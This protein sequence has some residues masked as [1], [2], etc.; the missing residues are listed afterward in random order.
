MGIFD[1]SNYIVNTGV[2]EQFFQCTTKIILLAKMI[3]LINSY[4]ADLADIVDATVSRCTRSPTI[5]SCICTAFVQT[6]LLQR[7]SWRCASPTSVTANICQ[8]T[9]TEHRQDLAALGRVKTQCIAVPGSW[10][11]HTAGR[12]HCFT[13]WPR[14]A[15]W[16]HNFGWFESRPARIRCQCNVLLLASSTSTCPPLTRHW[17]G[18]DA[19][20]CFCNVP[21]GL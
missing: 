8:Q 2:I 9:Q 11:S 1:K 4:V 21:G 3:K 14:P 10:S 7:L 6:S 20:A 5:H 19:R 18:G 13:V 12:R 15:D 16:S 17:I